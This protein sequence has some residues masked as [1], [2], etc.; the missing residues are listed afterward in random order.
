MPKK[1]GSLHVRRYWCGRIEQ[2]DT[3]KCT[4]QALPRAADQPA[5]TR[6]TGKTSLLVLKFGGTSVD[7]ADCMRRV[8]SIV[9]EAAR[10]TNVAVVVSAMKGVTDELLAASA[11]AQMRD[12]QTVGRIVDRLRQRHLSALAALV[13]SSYVRTA[14]AEHI[15]SVLGMCIHICEDVIAAGESTAAQRDAISGAGER[16]AAPMIAAALGERNIRT[17]SVD[18]TEVIVT[19]AN[20]GAAEPI[21]GRT[22]ERC[23]QRLG[24]MLA[25]GVVPV[26]TGFIGAT[27]EGV[28]T[29]LGR[30]GSDYSATVIASAIGAE[31]VEIWT[32]VDGFMTADP[33]AVPGT[34]LIPE[35]SYHDASALALFGAKVL[36]SKTL[37]AIQQL[38]VPLHI[39]KTFAPEMP[40]TKIVPRAS[41]QTPGIRGFAST[42]RIS[43]ITLQ[44]DAIAMNAGIR[45][46]AVDAIDRGRKDGLLLVASTSVNEIEIVC[47][48]C[49]TDIVGA[50]VQAFERELEAGILRRIHSRSDVGLVTAIG[51][52]LNAFAGT[53][54]EILQSHGIQLLCE[55][56]SE[57][58][59]RVSFLVRADDLSRTEI[60]LHSDLLAR[61]RG[62]ARR[63]VLLNSIRCSP[64]EAYDLA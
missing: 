50:L 55:S 51:S 21:M 24:P 28:P 49:E 2:A 6:E 45:T 58:G 18:A 39:R 57:D 29:T 37:S 20:H 36:H 41:D 33:N 35:L 32:D 38:G 27:A 60:A 15:C 63:R 43:L 11:A 4:S 10:T 47:G 42:E 23:G 7:G 48:R 53:A 3:S 17:E 31:G 9:Q 61:T 64:S 1:N 52:K 12:C 14:A 54:R 26:I 44:G 13:R 56:L 19:D 62:T 25:A 8:V 30:N 16:M 34:R 40:G 59:A 5:Q 22:R 46:R